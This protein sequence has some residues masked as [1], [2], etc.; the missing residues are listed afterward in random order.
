MWSR[1]YRLTVTRK[2]GSGIYHYLWLGG[3][4]IKFNLLNDSFV[5]NGTSVS[6][7]MWGVADL[8]PDQTGSYHGFK[9]VKKESYQN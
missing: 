9:A 8:Q 6:G 4:N 7:G 5:L 1:H 2:D 3:R